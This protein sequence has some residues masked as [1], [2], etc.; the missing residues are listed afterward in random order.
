MRS[1]PTRSHPA[2]RS[3][4]YVAAALALVLGP[5]VASARPKVQQAD[6]K[7]G[8]GP[9]GKSA[10]ACGAKVMPMVIGNTWTY[11]SIPA[12]QPAESAIARIAPAQPKTEI[13]R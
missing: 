5:T 11:S 6:A 12:P 4:P 13:G 1:S 7:A 9:T 3:H 8:G 2:T 10:P